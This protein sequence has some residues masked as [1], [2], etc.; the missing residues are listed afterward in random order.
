MNHVQLKLMCRRQASWN[1]WHSL[2]S[3]ELTKSIKCELNLIYEFEVVSTKKSIPFMIGLLQVLIQILFLFQLFVYT[4]FHAN[5]LQSMQTMTHTDPHLL[6]N[7]HWRTTHILTNNMQNGPY[8]RWFCCRCNAESTKRSTV[9]NTVQSRR[10]EEN[11]NNNRFHNKCRLVDFVQFFFLSLLIRFSAIKWITV[12]F[13][14]ITIYFFFQNCG[15]CCVHL[16][17]FHAQLPFI[18]WTEQKWQ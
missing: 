17:S 10:E 14:Y 4:A 13:F 8:S 15:V 5:K 18:Q 2:R 6:L 11:K 3:L 7:A 1:I 16:S 12:R 9:H